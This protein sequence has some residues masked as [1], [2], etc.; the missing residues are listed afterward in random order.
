MRR[1]LSIC[2][3]FAYK[4]NVTFNN[5]KS[6]CITIPPLLRACSTTAPP[7]SYA[8]DGKPIEN[9]D[10]WP[11]VGYK[12]NAHLTDDDDILTR[13]NIFIDQTNSFLCNFSI[14]D[15]KTKICCLNSIVAAIVAAFCG[16]LQIAN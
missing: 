5:M 1:M 3:Y 15:P 13:R 12:F 16:I 11:H 7:T 6:K 2:D 14:L 8:I 10:Q 4:S 9:V